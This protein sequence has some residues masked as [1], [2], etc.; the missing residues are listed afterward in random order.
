MTKPKT[1]G[2][3]LWTPAK[4][5]QD[6]LTNLN[7]MRGFSGVLATFW[8]WLSQPASSSSSRFNHLPLH[9]SWCVV[10]VPPQ[11][12]CGCI[13]QVALHIGGGWGDFPPHHC[14]VLRVL[15]CITYAYI[16]GIYSLLLTVLFNQWRTFSGSTHI[17]RSVP[18]ALYIKVVWFF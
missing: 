3:S 7:K 6:T 9:L 13:T 15:K 5:E 1:V 18:L 10:S 2:G 16:Q 12:G 11:S 8:A 17:L 4:V 14:K